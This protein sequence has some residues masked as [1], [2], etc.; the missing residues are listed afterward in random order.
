[1]GSLKLSSVSKQLNKVTSGLHIISRLL[2]W[3]NERYAHIR[4]LSPSCRL[5]L[6]SMTHLVETLWK[7]PFPRYG[8]QGCFWGQLEWLF[9]SASW[10]AK[11]SWKQVFVM[12]L[13]IEGPLLHTHHKP[14]PWKIYGALNIIQRP[15]RGNTEIQYFSW[16]ALKLSVEW[17]WTMLRDCHICSGLGPTMVI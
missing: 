9:S 17:K 8:L 12:K 4:F 2:C 15:Y 6:S 1:M 11:P 10:C 5:L 14:W 7:S 16:W 13:G 3:M